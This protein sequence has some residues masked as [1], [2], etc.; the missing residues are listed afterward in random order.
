MDP[1]K[2]AFRKIK[3]DMI[4]LHKEILILKQEIAGIKR[5]PNIQT[6]EA[7]SQTQ[8]NSIQTDEYP[9]EAQKSQNLALSTGN[10]GVQTDRQTN[11]QTDRQEEISRLEQVSKILESLD[12][13]K[14][15]LRAKFKRLTK[16]EMLVF[17]TIYL[18]E[19]KGLLVDY[20]LIAQK[21]SLSE[22][23]IRDYIKNLTRKGIP[24]KKIKENNK[25]IILS[26][27]SE[28]KK[29]TNLETINQ[30]RSL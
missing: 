1:L 14:K 12:E 11:R 8:I 28:L 6:K 19:E 20:S 29:V 30:L 10:K 13:V 3:E 25:K 5:T 23:V 16:Q 7:F 24:L 15:E 17:E 21:L 9:S 18:L 2:E 26:I 4:F 22:S 27:A